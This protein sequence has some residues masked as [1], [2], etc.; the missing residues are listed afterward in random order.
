VNIKRLLQITFIASALILVTYS[1]LASTN[2]IQADTLQWSY[3]LAEGTVIRWR[4]EEILSGPGDGLPQLA[5]YDVASQDVFEFR[6]PHAPPSL[7]SEWRASPSPTWVNMYLNDHQIDLTTQQD[8]DFFEGFLFPTNVFYNNG[9]SMDIEGIV[10]LPQPA[11]ANV[12]GVSYAAPNFYLSWEFENNITVSYYVNENGI[13]EYIHVTNTTSDL[14]WGMHIEQITVSSSTTTTTEEEEDDFPTIIGWDDS[15]VQGTIL[16]WEITYFNQIGGDPLSY[17]GVAIKQDDIIQFGYSKNPPTSSQP[18]FDPEGPPDWW[19]MYINGK[20]IDTSTIGSE[21]E[22][23][24]YLVLPTEYS[25]GNGTTLT[26]LEFLN[27]AAE[28]PSEDQLDFTVIVQGD[29]INVSWREEWED[30]GDSGESKTSYY[31]NKNT[32]IT[33]IFDINATEGHM[34]WEYYENASTV[35]DQGT[36]KTVESSYSIEI[37]FFT[38]GFEFFPLVMVTITLVFFRR[39]K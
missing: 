35:D 8:I 18:V 1:S 16:G 33:T 24:L 37:D 20:K 7:Y 34:T 32:G 30:N 11:T 14:Y 36:T 2:G 5:G 38:P 29:Y 10:H 17:G 12:I 31:I 39:K 19:N 28:N 27:M 13:A 22:M 3:N 9:T 23:L 15:I 21:G 25:F 4:F 6:L 26:L